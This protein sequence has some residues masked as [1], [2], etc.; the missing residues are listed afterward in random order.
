MSAFKKD[1]FAVTRIDYDQNNYIFSIDKK[2][3]ACEL[4]IY[5]ENFITP[6]HTKLES[7]LLAD[8]FVVQDFEQTMNRRKFKLDAD[9]RAVPMRDDA[10]LFSLQKTL[11]KGGNRAIK[12]FYN[13]ALANVWEYFCTF[14]FSDAN[15]RNDKTLLYQNY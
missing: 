13:Y 8:Y 9:G 2:G 14:T 1:D 11:R 4:V 6:K 15:V 12:T 5:A 7:D 3:E 10:T